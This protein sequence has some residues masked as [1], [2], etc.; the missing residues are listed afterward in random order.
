MSRPT[1]P[2]QIDVGQTIDRPR[3]ILGAV[4]RRSL[5]LGSP[6]CLA[7]GSPRGLAL[8]SANEAGGLVNAGLRTRVGVWCAP[9]QLLG[10][11]VRHD[12]VVVDGK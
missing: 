1:A 5:A 2:D 3:A 10:P 7:L 11:S 4:V 12:D 6:R 8:A 9:G